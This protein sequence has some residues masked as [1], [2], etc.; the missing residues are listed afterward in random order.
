MR[1]IVVIENPLMREGTASGRSTFFAICQFVAP[2]VFAASTTPGSTSWSA[3]STIL[4]TKGAAAMVSGTIAATGP[5]AFPT[6]NLVSGI[7][8]TIRITKGIER[9]TFIMAPRTVLRVLWGLMPL[10]SVTTIVTPRGSPIM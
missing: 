5:I 1:V 8:A 9:P 4:A 3:L 6:I 2:M 10:A 7:T